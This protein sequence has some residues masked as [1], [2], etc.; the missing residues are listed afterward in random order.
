MWHQKTGAERDF[1]N[2]VVDEYNAS[3]ADHYVDPLY[4]E[5]EE[6]RNLFIIASVGGQGPDLIFGPADNVSIFAL[7]ESIQPVTNVLEPGYLE[8]FSERGTVTWRDETWLVAD[9]IGNHL[10]FVYN[11]AL[12]PEPPTTVSEMISVLDSIT[13]D[14]DGDGRTDQY[15]L[16]WNYSE[17][18]FFVP[19][20]T[21]YGGGLMD[22]DG[23]PTLNTE[24]TISAIRLIL[25]MRD[26]YKVIPASTDY[27]T[28]ETLFKEGRSAAIING[29]WAWAGYSQVGIDYGLAR[30]PMIEE[31]GRW[32]APYISAKGYSVNVNLDQSKVPYARRVLEYLTGPDMQRRMANELATI[33]VIE[34][35]IADSVLMSSEL[36]QASLRQVEVGIPMPTAP[37]LRQIWDGMRGPYQL[38]MNGAVSPEEGAQMMQEEVE[39]RIA[40]TFL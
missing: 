39:K 32:A 6:G 25:E 29:P 36:L 2:R 4:K 1:F 34:S 22:E 12:L 13:A 35:V 14:L 26:T 17:P 18:F 7:T 37:Q 3:N 20:L 10:T 9:Q 24:A 28:A 30:I 5:N 11:K 33:P 38:I 27:D 16:T 15:G 8:T 19:F 23:K 31:T 40:D 21:A